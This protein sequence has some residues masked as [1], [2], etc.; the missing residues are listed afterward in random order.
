M[1]PLAYTRYGYVPKI[2]M[3]RQ[4]CESG[5]TTVNGYTTGIVDE[6][7]QQEQIERDMNKSRTHHKNGSAEV[8]WRTLRERSGA[9]LAASGMGCEFYFDSA[10]TFVFN[11]NE[12]SGTES[13]VIGSTAESPAVTCGQPDRSGLKRDFGSTAWWHNDGTLSWDGT[14]HPKQKSGR[15]GARGIFIGHGTEQKGFKMILLVSEKIVCDWDV[16]VPDNGLTTTLDMLRDLRSDPFKEWLAGRFVWK[17]F[18]RDAPEQRAF[19]THQPVLD[20]AGDLFDVVGDDGGAVMSPK[21]DDEESAGADHR[22]PVGAERS[23][24]GVGTTGRADEADHRVSV[25]AGMV[26][27]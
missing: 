10:D 22:F 3:L 13:N 5:S 1:A 8:M 4:D 12:S 26:S 11:W 20:A 6:W 19:V 15:R 7:L 14:V 16:K 24:T 18:D 23:E 27:G 21:P 17:V 9:Q 25:G 2:T